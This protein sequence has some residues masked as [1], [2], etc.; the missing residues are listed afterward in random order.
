MLFRSMSGLISSIT[1]QLSGIG[2]VAQDSSG[3]IRLVEPLSPYKGGAISQTSAPVSIFGSGPT[4]TVGTASTGGSPEQPAS[5][6]LKFDDGSPF[7]GLPAGQQR[8]A[9]GYSGFRYQISAVSGL[10]ASVLR[11]TDTGVVDSSWAGFTARTLLDF[12]M[13]GSGGSGNWIGSFMGCPEY[14]LATDAEY[15]V[16]F[17]QGLCYYSKKGNI[18]TLSKSVQ[19]RWR[20]A[21]VGGAWTNITHTYTEIGRASCRERVS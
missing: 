11:I 18:K 1:S 8:L 13:T 21:A 15:D 14:E 12:S 19:V 16:F 3:R 6:T 17:S 9:V 2:L 7:S 4:Y 10:T 5:I 20:D